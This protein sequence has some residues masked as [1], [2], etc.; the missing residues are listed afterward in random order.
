M[1]LTTFQKFRTICNRYN[2]YYDQLEQNIDHFV[3]RKMML[4][5]YD[6]F[7]TDIDFE[8]FVRNVHN[9]PLD[10]LYELSEQ[11]E[12]NVQE[13]DLLNN[14]FDDKERKHFGI[15]YKGF[16]FFLTHHCNDYSI[17]LSLNDFR[18]K[19]QDTIGL[20]YLTSYSTNNP[21]VL[22]KHIGTIRTEKLEQYINKFLK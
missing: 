18:T 4:K 14:C 9:N 13:I 17:P 8:T 2:F 7:H 22:R 11:M 20:T 10:Y 16:W 12:R 6:N 19:N 15:K 5:I 1:Q 3:L 21:N